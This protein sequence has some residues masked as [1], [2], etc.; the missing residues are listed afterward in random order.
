MSTA[1][2]LSFLP[3]VVYLTTVTVLLLTIR[4]CP[5]QVHPVAAVLGVGAQVFF[6]GWGSALTSAGVGCAMF[7]LG[8]LL[9]S[10]LVSGAT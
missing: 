1:Q 3:V 10:R 4:R 9:T 6:S 7:V 8:V 5:V 2:V